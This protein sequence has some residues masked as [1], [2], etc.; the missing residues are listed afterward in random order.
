MRQYA[1]LVCASIE[2]RF[3]LES[4]LEI[5]PAFPKCCAQLL[6]AIEDPDL[7]AHGR[8]SKVQDSPDH[9]E[10]TVFRVDVD[11]IKS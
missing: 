10:D 1:P 3:F 9:L 6:P 7:P 5:R 2:A 8:L 11:E 4:S